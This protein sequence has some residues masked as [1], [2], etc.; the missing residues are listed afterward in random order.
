MKTEGNQS[1]LGG[2]LCNTSIRPLCLRK[3]VTAG[4]SQYMSWGN[5]SLCRQNTEEESKLWKNRDTEQWLGN[6]AQ[7]G[8]WVCFVL[9]QQKRNCVC[10][11]GG[12]SQRR[13]GSCTRGDGRAV[14]WWGGKRI[15]KS[16]WKNEKHLKSSAWRK[17]NKRWSLIFLLLF[18]F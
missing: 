7:A 4:W 5:Y 2:I 9:R 13:P 15:S 1:Q 11:A 8:M 10:I 12:K 6:Q 3:A 14:Q 16:A 17:E 18:C